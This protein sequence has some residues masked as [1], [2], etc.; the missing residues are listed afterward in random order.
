MT[1]R[2]LIPGILGL[3]LTLDR[4]LVPEPS[5]VATV[6]AARPFPTL[7]VLPGGKAA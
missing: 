4:P 5:A 7:R 3:E 2:L 6:R 1:L